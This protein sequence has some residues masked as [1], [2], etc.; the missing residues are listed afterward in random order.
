MPWRLDVEQKRNHVDIQS[1]A[2][3]NVDNLSNV[4]MSI[5]NRDSGNLESFEIYTNHSVDRV[6]PSNIWDQR[7]ESTCEG[8]M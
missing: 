6:Q 3:G 5:V 4:T 7:N 1:Y 2:E 8:E